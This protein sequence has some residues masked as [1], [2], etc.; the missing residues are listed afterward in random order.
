M[1]GIICLENYFKHKDKVKALVLI[2][3][4]SV[5]PISDILINA[6]IYDFDAFFDKMLHRIFHKKAGIFIL[7]AKKN[8]T[9]NEKKII[10][11]DLRL[12]S[13]LNYN[14]QLDE[15]GAPVLLIANKYDRMVPSYLTEDMNWKIKNSKII[16]FDSEGHV[17]FFE[18]SNEF[19]DVM[20]EF[21]ESIQ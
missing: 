21:I 8:I 16:I 19:N 1:G 14:K 4:S 12:C 6:S 7:A 18:N 9:D 15:I 20:Q 11:D 2:S 17:P 10:T 13:I 3:T 5:L